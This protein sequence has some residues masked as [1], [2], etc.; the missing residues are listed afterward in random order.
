MSENMEKLAFGFG[1][2]FNRRSR[3]FMPKIADDILEDG[4]EKIANY[5]N[6]GEDTMNKS[7]FDIVDNVFE[8]IANTKRTLEDDQKRELNRNTRNAQK[9]L[10][11]RRNNPKSQLKNSLA[12]AAGAAAGV[13]LGYGAYRGVLKA[14]TFN[15][16]RKA[17]KASKELANRKVFDN[18]D[19]YKKMSSMATKLNSQANFD[20]KIAQQAAKQM[21]LNRVFMTTG[22]LAGS[23]I[24]AAMRD[25]HEVKKFM[26]ERYG[27]NYKPTIKQ[28][29][30]EKMLNRA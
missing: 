26:K 22:G 28:N 14:S 9:S 16:V 25:N 1:F 30:R 27:E 6:K 21:G 5:E 3:R 19:Q 23:A 29:E 20:K 4:F 7:A 12:G 8:K 18:M 13:G 10:A 11:Y 2:G 17:A 24:G 15:S